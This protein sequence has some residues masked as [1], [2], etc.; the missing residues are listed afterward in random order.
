MPRLN[1]EERIILIRNG[2]V[3]FPPFLKGLM[4]NGLT[5]TLEH[6]DAGTASLQLWCRLQVQLRS[7]SEHFIC[8]RVAKKGKTNK[9]TK[10]KQTKKQRKE[11]VLRN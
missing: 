4:G 11:M 7:I 5:A 8:H 9:Q 1:E 3:E 10:N 2:A 6:W